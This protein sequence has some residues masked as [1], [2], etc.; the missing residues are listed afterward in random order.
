MDLIDPETRAHVRAALTKRAKL[1]SADALR[2]GL[3][4]LDAATTC[5]A[6]L[7]DRD[8][9]PEEHHRVL[10]ET[11]AHV[12]AADSYFEVARN[13]AQPVALDDDDDAAEADALADPE[14]RAIRET[15]RAH[16]A[17]V[18]VTGGNVG[19]AQ[20]LVRKPGDRRPR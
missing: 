15:T 4:H 6:S 11:H 18:L 8:A 1:K 9:D 16:A 5:R 2:C 13:G 12:K 10:S 3:E 20:K 14:V 19:G 17:A 7:P